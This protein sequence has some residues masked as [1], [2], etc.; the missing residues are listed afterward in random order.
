LTSAQA[1]SDFVKFTATGS[2]DNFQ[3]TSAATSL[4]GQGANESAYF[5]TDANGNP[6]P[7][8]GAWD[9]GAFAFGSTG[10]AGPTLTLSALSQNASDV[11]A[12]TTG[13][14]V[15]EGTIVQYSGTAT[16]NSTNNVSWQWSYQLNGAS[17]V[18]YLS[19][20][21]TVTPV[22]FD[23]P[24]G[25]GGNTYVWTLSAGDGKTNLT[26]QI[27]TS[28]E[29]PPAPLSGL[30]FQASQGVITAPF[31]LASGSVSQSVQTTTVAAAGED[32]FSFSITNAGNYIVQA[33]VNAPNESANSMY[34]NVDAQ[35]VDPT[36]IWD[37]PVTTNFQSRIISWRG[38]GT[39]TN[40]QYV[41]KVFSL[42]TGTHSLIIGGREANTQLQ[43]VSI[44]QLPNAPQN[45]RVLPTVVNAPTFS[46]GP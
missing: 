40:N 34:V 20:T 36:M 15:Y 33:S 13:V 28:V 41:P 38:N 14:Q 39:D 2:V 27:T 11:D 46:A 6:R 30:S 5:T 43:S 44:L 8:S 45:L 42:T 17:P 12:T 10:G 24:T 9:I 3:L 7:A 18:V 31:T 26:A 29:V 16:E 35:P 37:I 32:T 1:S 25:T 23:Y 22:S 19:G 4:I 21:G